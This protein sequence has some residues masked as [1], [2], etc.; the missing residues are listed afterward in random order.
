MKNYQL[1]F[2][3]H[4][5]IY[6]LKTKLRGKAV[7]S[8]PQLNKGTAFDDRERNEL[9]LRGKLPV[10]IETLSEQVER[11]HAQYLRFNEPLNQSIFLHELQNTNEILFYALLKKYFVDMMPIIYT[12][13][14][15]AFTKQFSLQYRQSRGLFISYADRQYIDKIIANRTNEEVDLIVMTD[16]AGVL[17]LGD[18][19][20]DGMS[21]PIAKLNLYSTCG[22]NPLKTL[23][24]MLDVGTNNPHLLSSPYYLG[25]RSQRLDQSTYDQF[26]LEVITSL[27]KAFPNAFLHW[28]DFSR[29]DALRHLQS[30][31]HA[32]CSFND[33]IQG[34][35]VVALAAILTGIGINK[36]KLADQ[37]IL[38]FGAGTAGMGIIN[39]I[40]DALKREG[41]SEDKIKSTLW[42]FDRQG[43]IIEGMPGLTSEQQRFAAQK[44][45]V[46][47]WENTTDLVAV[48]RKIK[49]TILIGCSGKEGAFTREV[50]IE[51][52][53][54]T[55]TPILLPLSNPTEMVEAIPDDILDW[56]NSQAMVA[57]GSP[58][59]NYV[60]DNKSTR[61]GQCNNAFAF[62]GIGLG[63]TAIKA[64]MISEGMLYSA[65]KAL[66]DYTL[67]N[68]DK[69]ASLIPETKK[70]PLIAKIIALEVAK[71]AC[72]EGLAKQPVAEDKLSEL[73]DKIY[74]NPKYLPIYTIED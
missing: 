74:W 33:D 11:I 21:I 56:T 60:R 6:V 61:I 50:V 28:E 43:L 14:V 45:L 7:F 44:K 49:P 42:L 12:P 59:P 22:I 1:M 53:K 5:M 68:Q 30:Y 57:T 31:K 52:H 62:P 16:G 17:G 46:D 8:I 72:R 67:S 15:G 69:Q 4:E 54:H 18:Q 65:S 63:V 38:M 25:W 23:P 47:N 29:N 41:V 26:V 66:S 19:G 55:D 35:G 24:I 10:R 9:G 64:S 34:T 58:F 48:I 27:Q 70:I 39:T 32:M 40:H 51:M 71:A 73:I 3:E 2:D 36:T 20:I 13:V 37:T